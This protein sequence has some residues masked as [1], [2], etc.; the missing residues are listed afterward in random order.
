MSARVNGIV[1]EGQDNDDTIPSKS[2]KTSTPTT[3]KPVAVAVTDHEE[4]RESWG[5]KLEFL[6]ATIGFAV[7]LGNVW[8]FPY[9]CQK[10][11]GGAFL[12]PYFISLF[13]LGIP[14]FVIELG[15]GQR[16]RNGSIG[17][18][19]QVSPYLGGIGVTSLVASCFICIYYNMIVA[20]CFYYLF[21]S[22]Q[23]PLPYQDCPTVDGNKTEPECALAGET[24]Y[25]WYRKALGLSPSITESGEVQWHLA[26][27]LLLAWL[28]VFLCT[29]KGVKSTGK[30]VYVTALFPYLVLVIFFFRA[31]TLDGAGDGLKR[32]FTPKFETL[33]DPRVWLEAATQ[34]F[35]S[36]SLSFGGLIAM[37][38]FNPVKNNCKKDAI[39]VSLINCGTSIF[40]SIVVFSVLGFKA[41]TARD[42]CLEEEARNLTARNFTCKSLDDYL[43]DV[44]QGTGLSFIAFT[45]AITKM[46]A[47]QVWS[48]LF[49][50][51]LITLGLGSM[52]GNIAG[53]VTPILDMGLLKIKKEYLNAIMSTI[54]FLFGLLLCQNSGEYWL[55][56]FDS[57]SLNLALLW[58]ALFHLIG[59]NFVYGTERFRDD[60]EY[61]TGTRPG[62]YWVIT[63]RYIGPVLAVLLFIAGLYD[64]SD[65]GIGYSAWDKE[66]G[67]TKS[68]EFP[69][70]GDAMV[71]ILVCLALM[72]VPF[73]A[74]LRYFRLCTYLG[75]TTDRNFQNTTSRLEL[76]NGIDEKP[77]LGTTGGDYD[78]RL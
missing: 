38:S 1:N 58:I 45:E 76:T 47:P 34:I 36:L 16:L 5:N 56:L 21:I 70:W 72:C 2:A 12:I 13:L 61:M 60:V 73:V 69:P 22:F 27:V 40:A 17:V 3:D 42:E 35:F 57:Y 11:G 23:D 54:L 8:R 44:A 67:K 29:M 28:V 49:F 59:M 55:Q 50:L 71:I 14:L 63:W 52:F 25:Y 53:V 75:K 9:L 20:W 31:V 68:A 74:I 19:N 30:A 48:V 33:G 66:E 65:K 10:N 4:K 18:W 7:G 64:M 51:M 39:M 62:M 6:L 46:P 41:K 26:L 32:M 15:M 77:P 78:S 37:A 24:S 43:S